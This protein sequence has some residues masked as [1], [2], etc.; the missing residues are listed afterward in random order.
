VKPQLLTVP[1]KSEQSFSVRRDIVPYFYNRWHYHPDVEL[2]HLEA[3]SGTQ[4]IGDRIQPFSAGDLL[5]IGSNLPHYWRCDDAYFAED[6]TRRA[7]ATVVHFKEECLGKSFLQLPESRDVRSLLETAR[8]GMRLHGALQKAVARKL[9]LLLN[10]NGLKRITLL[11]DILDQIA[12]SD[13]RT[14][15]TTATLFRPT[16]EVDT[17]RINRILQYSLENFQRPIT[18]QQIADVATMSPNAFCR[19]FKAHNRKTYSQFLTELRVGKAC[20][21]LLANKTSIAR[22][23]YESG[24]NS[25]SNFNKYFRAVMGMSPLKYQQQYLKPTRLPE[26]V[27]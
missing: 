3:G 4:F 26:L 8:L 15:L 5:L 25:V 11:L 12:H 2:V 21:L 17:E 7:I 1:L 9:R 19:Y 23:G 20:S 16:D 14:L 24:F 13:E 27:P 22:V 10:A 18:L 6:S